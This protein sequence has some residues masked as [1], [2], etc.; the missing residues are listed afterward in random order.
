MR[1]SSFTGSIVASLLFTSAALAQ[2]SGPPLP[3]ATPIPTP[4][5]NAP[6][7]TS[8]G[9]PAS[10]PL[11]TV[12]DPMLAPVPRAPKE[13]ATWQEALA[14]VR[15]R[16]TDLRT[17]YDQVIEAEAQ[18]RLALSA[19]LGD[20]YLSANGTH[21]LIVNHVANGINVTGTTVSIGNQP[22]PLPSY[23][24]GGFT[25]QQTILNLEQFYAIGTAR[26]ATKSAALSYED[27]KRTIGLSVANSIVVRHH[28]RARRRDQP[29]RAP[30]VARTA[31]PAPSEDAPRRGDGLDVVRAQ[32]DVETARTTLV[33]GD[34]TLRKARESLGLAVGIP[35][36]SA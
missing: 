22:T 4:P 10:L 31:R 9:A 23:A 17:S 29:R 1:S 3:S 26:E 34:E 11:P 32:Q 14:L 27:M 6:A 15:A 5:Q 8:P 13:I 33:N 36:R 16:S 21:N 30:P 20:F 12:D 25:L 24:T 19:I 18:E 35:T 7:T 2:P 28:G